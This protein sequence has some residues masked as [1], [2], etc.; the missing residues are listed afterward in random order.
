MTIVSTTLCYPTPA[1][2][3]Q[4]V[5]VARRLR[6]VHE[7]M[8]VKVVAPQPRFGVGPI[9]WP[10]GG[11]A[12]AVDVQ[13]NP[14]VWRPTMRYLPRVAKSLD[15]WFY[16][17][18]LLA[19]IR[20]AMGN[21]RPALIDAHFEW[22]DGVGASLAAKALRVPFVLTL[23]GKLVS[24]SQVAS[25]RWR[26]AAAIAGADAV[27]SVSRALADLACELV[28]RQLDVRVIPN[29]VD[30]S[31]FASRDRAAARAA[32]GLEA[33]AKYVVSV[34]HMQELKGFARLVEVWSV[35]RQR[36]G[37][38]RLILIGGGAQEPGYERALRRRIGE[39]GL[40]DAVLIVGR[41]PS[42]RVAEYLNAAD[43]FALW[44]RSE[45][46][47]NALVESLACG[48]PVV[49]SA[50]GG[51]SEIVSQDSLGR[52]V[53]FDDRG[54]WVEA[55]LVA[56]ARPW[57]RDHIARRGSL[58]DWQQVGAECVDVFR[59]VLNRRGGA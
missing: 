17:R 45:G 28:G 14:P 49:A 4:G 35:V 25:M 55:I 57:D 40:S 6:A 21:E 43:L 41:Q 46:W 11:L 32:L 39:L 29:G 18:A 7:Q 23:R 44:T 33:G 9:G 26:M 3:T 20:S 1:S 34:G 24:R 15:A 8:P 31:V 5:F 16:C 30:G 38:V 52:L 50:V 42:E 58:R 53:P 54:G 10:P 19:G 56:L 48:C 13:E 36:G 47:C 51:N 12:P 37:D 59:E 2:P 27:I 22:P